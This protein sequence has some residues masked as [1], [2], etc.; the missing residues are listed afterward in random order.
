MDHLYDLAVVGAGLA[1]LSFLQAGGAPGATVVL[2][3]QEAPGGFLRAALSAPGFEDAAAVI[4]GAHRVPGVEIRLGAAAVELLPAS[5]PGASHT[6]LVRT[7]QGLDRTRARRLLIA[8][9]GLEVPREHDQIPGTRPAGVVT[10]IFVHQLLDRRYLPGRRAVVYGSARY[11]AATA[12]R[13][14]DAGVAVTLVPPPGTRAPNVHHAVHIERPAELV[15]IGGFPR[16]ERISLRRDGQLIDLPADTL[17]YATE[18]MANT[19]WLKGSD[20]AL[21]THGAILVDERYE[22]NVPEVY[23]I[24]TVVAP[25]LDHVQSVSMGRMVGSVLRGGPA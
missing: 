18:M 17:V 10:P 1:A 4:G 13:L 21:D 15:H 25:S 22:T 14:A 2:E 8:C 5:E 20:V 6:V 3:Y 24:G 23:A 11:A 16:L 9:G 7:R 19:T 12:R